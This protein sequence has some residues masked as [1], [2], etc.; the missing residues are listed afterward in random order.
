MILGLCVCNFIDS[1][2]ILATGVEDKSVQHEDRD[3]D[4]ERSRGEPGTT[5]PQSPAC[6]QH[7]Q[8]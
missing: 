4:D 1:R 6:I 3:A 8:L 2:M 5:H 7:Q